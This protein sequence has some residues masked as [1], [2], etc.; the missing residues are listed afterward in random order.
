VLKEFLGEMFSGV[1][2][3]DYQSLSE[4]WHCHKS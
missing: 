1:V 2:G 3:C 4:Y